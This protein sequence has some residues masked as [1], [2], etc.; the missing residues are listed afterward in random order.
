MASLLSVSCLLGC[1][2]TSPVIPIAPLEPPRMEAISIQQMKAYPEL[3]TRRFVS[4]V[5]FE[6]TA[7]GGRPGHE[8]VDMFSVEPELPGAHREFV[9]NITRTGAG[10]MEVTLPKSARLVYKIPGYRDFRGY[11]LLSMALYCESVRDDLCVT[12]STDSAFWVSHRTLVQPGWNNILIDIQRLNSWPGF[13]ITAVNTI[14]LSFDDATGPVEF[15]IDD[16]ML[17]N[18]RREFTSLPP[19][20]AL[21]KEGLDYRLTVAP[22]AEQISLIQCSDGL[23][24]MGSDQTAIQVSSPGEQLPSV[25]EHMQLM[26]SR[27]VGYVEVLEANPMRIRLANTWYFPTRAGEW[28]SLAV[29]QIRWEYTFYADG[30]RVTNVELNNSGG[31]D[32]GTFRMWLEREVAW[33]TGVLARDMVIRDF[34]GPIGRWSFMQAAAGGLKRQRL[35]GNFIRPA[36]IDCTV[37]DGQGFASGDED[38][39]R[40]DESQGCYYLQSINGHCRFRIIPSVD[41]VLD[42]IFRIAGPWEGEV[43]VNIQGLAIR[44]IER[45]DDGSVIFVIPGWI[46]RATEIEVTGE[47]R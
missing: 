23:W 28:V 19:G 4:L 12:I 24:R 10:A 18:N 29:R 44:D 20:F 45:L 22:L 30:R 16:I 47:T 36:Q 31:R 17:V 39:D 25:G 40:F 26:G 43:S 41:G 27:K 21:S 34:E 8:Q 2:Q 1:S 15:N 35:E 32:I 11:T 7:P 14:E 42:P 13:D 3:V 33:S 38:G 9:V 5:D 46:R 6:E 37:A